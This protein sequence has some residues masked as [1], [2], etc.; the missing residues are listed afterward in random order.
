MKK[1]FDMDLSK[2]TEQI[3][4]LLITE[5]QENI[6]LAAITSVNLGIEITDKQIAKAMYDSAEQGGKLTFFFKA[7]DTKDLI[8]DW[9]SA[10]EIA[11]A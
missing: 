6:I 5:E 1:G 7:W 2:E 4:N 11:K 10:L 8:E 9:Y 3:L